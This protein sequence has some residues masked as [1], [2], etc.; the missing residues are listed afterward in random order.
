MKFEEDDLSH[1]M[2]ERMLIDA[3]K[4]KEWHIR[5]VAYYEGK[6]EVYSNLLNE[7]LKGGK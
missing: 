7:K 4:S 2:L 5:Q 3:I 6:I 1:I